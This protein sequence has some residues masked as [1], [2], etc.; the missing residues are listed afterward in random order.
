MRRPPKVLAE[1]DEELAGKH[2]TVMVLHV[3]ELPRNLTE[4]R[5]YFK[6]P[7]AMEVVG[8][9]RTHEKEQPDDIEE[10]EGVRLE[11]ATALK[12]LQRQDGSSHVRAET[13]GAQAPARLLRNL[14]EK[15]LSA[16]VA[17][18][19]YQEAERIPDMPKL[20]KLPSVMQQQLPNVTHHPFAAWCEACVLG[21]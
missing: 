2:D 18:K 11:Q 9:G 14:V 17:R 4:P 8:E 5:D 15:R 7:F 21:R 6:E 3:D 12:E 20:P 16:E 19:M 10:L 1:I 13:K